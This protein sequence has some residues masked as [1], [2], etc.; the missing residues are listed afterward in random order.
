MIGGV[1][2]RARILGALAGALCVVLAGCG[3][4]PTTAPSP[5]TTAP[6]GT[7]TFPV[8]I[9]HK[10]GSTT[11]SAPPQRVVTVGDEDIAFAL[12][13]T[14]VGIVRNTSTESGIAPWLESRIDRTKTTLIDV[15]PGAEGE[16]AAGVNI[17]QVAALKPDLILAINDYGLEIDYPNLAKIA[18]TVG[19]QRA[20]GEQGWQEQ[21]MIG[22]RALGLE[23]RGRQVVAETEAATH[24]VRDANPGLIGRTV[25][26]SFVYGPGQISTLKSAQD[27]GV[28][29][30]QELGMQLPQSV[31][32]LPDIAPD[33]PG[34]ALSFENIS[35]LDADVIVM[36]YVTKELQD[37][38]ENLEL[39]K[40]LRGVQAKGYI[41]LDLPTVSALRS[42]TVLSIRW[43]LDQIK[44]SLTRVAG[45]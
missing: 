19:Y 30:L 13:I 6:S 14:P 20:W 12:G 31:R 35:L 41:V 28:K 36:A 9:T 27:P 7:S 2:R 40:K 26:Y 15:P 37:Q 34:G 1:A 21:T 29:L 11:I 3:S 5:T 38:V 4:S 23:E 32:D 33:N 16:G 45:Q 42:P 10:F 22:A 25:T 43:G 17:E 8:T 39:F 44:P 24:A 18:P